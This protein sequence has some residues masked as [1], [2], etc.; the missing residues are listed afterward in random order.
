M[1]D[2]IAKLHSK[3]DNS[4]TVFQI[5]AVY[6]A[7]VQVEKDKGEEDIKHSLLV[8]VPT[9]LFPNIRALVLRATAESGFPPFQMQIVDFEELYKEKGKK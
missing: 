3:L 9:Q 5:D 4:K 6:S 1:V 2:L 8:E 7:L